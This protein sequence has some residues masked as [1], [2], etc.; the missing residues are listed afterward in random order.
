MAK[1]VV[2][3]A[4]FHKSGTTALQSSFA[5]NKETLDAHDIV[6]PAAARHAHHRAVWGLT[7]R[8]WGWRDNGGKA[9]SGSEWDG[10]VRRIK[11]S[12]Q[13]VLISSEFFTEAKHEHL[14]RI[15]KD[16]HGTPIE[17]VFTSRPFSKILASSYQQYLKYGVRLRYDAWLDEMFHRH[18]SSK[19]TP[20]F[21]P[22]S[23]V[24]E[25]V[26]R[27]V[28]VFGNENVTVILAD[29]SSPRFIFDEFERILG[30]T[31][32]SLR[33]PNVGLNRSMTLEE[34]HLL[35]LINGIYDR[36]KGWDEYRS[37]IREGYVRFLADH[38][39]PGEGAKR[40]PTP[41]W[42]VDESLALTKRHLEAITRMGVEV[43]GDRERYL[44]ASVPTGEYEAPEGIDI[45]L[46]A[47]FLASYRFD[48]VQ[49]MPLRVLLAELKRRT[50]RFVRKRVKGR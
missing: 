7:G 27:W 13:T 44:G 17:I 28:D 48:I 20:T 37:M 1:R 21:W 6:Y 12:N 24:D 15:C 38:T 8:V 25:V 43:R 11:R 39:S 22:R 10:L 3:H 33:L 45:E 23:Q 5:Q 18:Q 2:I 35:F 16:L 29:E 26:S 36:S 4:G 49:Q 50:R 32:G 42:A 14:E 19:V 46:A 31:Q 40:L 34:T 41:Q 9:I 47:R 30:L